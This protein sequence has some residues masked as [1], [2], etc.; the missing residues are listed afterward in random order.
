MK[1]Y[2][3]TLHKTYFTEGF[4]NV[5]VDFDHFVRA[6]E[7][8]IKIELDGRIIEGTVNRSSN[9]NGTARIM[10]GVALRDWFQ[11]NFSLKD[12]VEVEFQNKNKINLSVP[13]VGQPITEY[14]WSRLNHLQIGKYAEYLMKMKFTQYGLDVYT[15]EVDDRGIDFVLRLSASLYIDIQVKSARNMNY[16]FFP[17]R[18]FHPRDNLYAA[19]VLFKDDQPAKYFLIPSIDWMKPNNLLVSRDYKGAASKPEWGINLSQKYLEL[20]KRYK[21]ERIIGSLIE[22]ISFGSP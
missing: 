8:T 16:I 6:K 2:Q 17:K 21:F 9:Q 19:V 14:S 11:D 15:S 13:S 12:V 20:F 3:L 18:N 4:F 1:I 7:G 22:Q 5:P 10:G